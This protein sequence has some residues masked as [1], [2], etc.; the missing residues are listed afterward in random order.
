MLLCDFTDP[1]DVD[2]RSVGEQDVQAPA[3]IGH[4]GV[5]PAAIPLFTAIPLH[6]SDTV[7]YFLDR[8]IE[9]SL[10]PSVDEDVRTLLDEPLGGGQPDA[11]RTAGNHRGLALQKCHVHASR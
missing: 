11:R 5:E 8:R 6:T 1:C 7:A 2:D 3:S 4:R 10:A 9:L